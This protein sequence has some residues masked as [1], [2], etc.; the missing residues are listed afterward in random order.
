MVG[1]PFRELLKQH[2]ED[3]RCAVC[4]RNI[5]PA[6]FAFQ[7]FDISGRWRNVEHESYKRGE[8]DGR[9]SWLGVGKTRPVDTVGP[10]YR[11]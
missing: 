10:L 11:E 6:G 7:N 3:K 9:I 5:D 2:Q 1:K 4:H 8:L